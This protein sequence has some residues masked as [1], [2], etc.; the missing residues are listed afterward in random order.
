MFTV[1]ASGPEVGQVLGMA[2]AT[3]AD[4]TKAAMAAVTTKTSGPA[5]TRPTIPRDQPKVPLANTASSQHCPP[6]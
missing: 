2:S 5:L 1:P 4:A 6:C 3:G